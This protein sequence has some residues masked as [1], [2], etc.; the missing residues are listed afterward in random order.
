[1]VLLFKKLEVIRRQRLDSSYTVYHFL[2]HTFLLYAVSDSYEFCFWNISMWFWHP[3]FYILSL[4][5][6]WS[7]RSTS[8]YVCCRSTSSCITATWND[9]C[10]I[11]VFMSSPRSAGKI[12]SCIFLCFVYLVLYIVVFCCCCF[13]SVIYIYIYLYLNSKTE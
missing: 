1:M 7:S 5:G 9:S 13:S 3:R 4:A 12:L 11:T 10:W 8:A 2:V 6:Y